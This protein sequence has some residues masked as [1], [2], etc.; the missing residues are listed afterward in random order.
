MILM[1]HTTLSEKMMRLS[2]V[3][4]DTL[5]SRNTMKSRTMNNLKDVKFRINRRSSSIKTPDSYKGINWDRQIE[6]RKSSICC[7]VDHAFLIVKR[8]FGYCK[9]A[10]RGIAKNMHRFN[11]LFASAN[12]VMC[13]RAGRT[14][15]LAEVG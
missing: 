4:Q 14:A 1:K 7:K 8:Q 13:A 2:M 3:I 9:T 15:E 10:Y 12:L 6:H 5:A 11:F